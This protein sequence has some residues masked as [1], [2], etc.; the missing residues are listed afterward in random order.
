MNDILAALVVVVGL[1]AAFSLASL[2][3][4][5]GAKRAAKT[6]GQEAARAVKAQINFALS[7]IG[8]ELPPTAEIPVVVVPVRNGG[9]AKFSASG[10]RGD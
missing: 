5:V 8:E 7:R 10:R 3:V 6:A 4:A 1:N 2:F 9:A